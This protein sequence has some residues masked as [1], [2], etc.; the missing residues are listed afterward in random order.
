MD[1]FDAG[2]INLAQINSST[3][4]PI[5]TPRGLVAPMMRK[6]RTLTVVMGFIIRGRP[7]LDNVTYLFPVRLPVAWSTH[8]ANG[9]GA[10]AAVVMSVICVKSKR[11]S[12]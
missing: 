1:P 6:P 2:A 5:K 11:P 10:I 12:G 9:A 8:N 4:E 7:T 3:A